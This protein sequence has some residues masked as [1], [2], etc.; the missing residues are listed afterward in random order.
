[1]VKGGLIGIF[2]SNAGHIQLVSQRA[3][4][5]GQGRAMKVNNEQ[6]LLLQQE[7]LY[8]EKVHSVG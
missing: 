5:R 6:N 1:M 7:Q 8:M 2:P 4:L 3:K